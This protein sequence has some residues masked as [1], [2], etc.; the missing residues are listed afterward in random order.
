M[1]SPQ[2]MPSHQPPRRP[3]APGQPPLPQQHESAALRGLRVVTY[4]LTSLASITFLA[5]VLWATVKINQLQTA[6]Q[7]SPLGRL[8]SLTSSPSTSVPGGST[9]L[10]CLQFPDAQGC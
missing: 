8:S 4:I 10:F 7:D 1:T 2:Y 6:W 9:E 5:V 3:V